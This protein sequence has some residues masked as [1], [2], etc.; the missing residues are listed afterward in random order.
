M[1]VFIQAR[2][3]CNLA[4][5]Q[6]IGPN[7]IPWKT[8]PAISSNKIFELNTYVSKSYLKGF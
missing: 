1:A 8:E 2:F 5:D 3:V 7:V 6:H 4:S